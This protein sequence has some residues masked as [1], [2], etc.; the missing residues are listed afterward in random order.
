MRNRKRHGVVLALA[1]VAALAL[2]AV[3]VAAPD[4]NSSSVTG[5]KISPSTLPKTTYKAATLTVHTHA[6]Y[7]N[8]GSSTQGGFTDHAQIYFDNDGKLNATGIPT[9]DKSKVSG[10]KSLKQ[11]MAACGSSKVGSG[12]AA[13]Y[14]GAN[15]IHGCALVF[16]GKKNGSGQPTDLIFTRVNAAPPFTMSCANPASNQAGNT[17]VLL[18]GSIKPN[19]SSLG[20]DF[21]GGKMLDVPN[22]K[23]ASPLPLIDFNV[24][25]NKGKYITA[26]CHDANKQLN[27]KAKFTYTDGQSDSPSSTQTCK[28][29]G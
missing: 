27:I 24:K 7:A 20:S 12:T 29:G 3:A 21:A 22:I 23:A 2:V 10:T 13:A 18:V 8:P 26:R 28:V 19:P 16:N 15:Q 17:N 5:S 11:A 14:A 6:N 25:V 1:A 4:G 9:C